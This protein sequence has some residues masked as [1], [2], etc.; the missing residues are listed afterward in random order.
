MLPVGVLIH[1]IRLLSRLAAQGTILSPEGDFAALC[2]V[3]ILKFNS[4][5]TIVVPSST[6]PPEMP[7]F[8]PHI[9]ATSEKDTQRIGKQRL[10][11][12]Q[13]TCTGKLKLET[14]VGP[15]STKS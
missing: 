6:D 5:R 9:Q 4:Q 3:Q 13:K 12:K 7:H 10:L 8:S 14:W 15:R 11:L 2:S 1:S